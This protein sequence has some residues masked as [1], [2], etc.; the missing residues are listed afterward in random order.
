MGGTIYIIIQI[1]IAIYCVYIAL[2]LWLKSEAREDDKKNRESSAQD[3][4]RS[5]NK[6]TE[7]NDL[8]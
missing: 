1:A 3:S 6:E 7:P 8:Y 2:T 5:R 4:D